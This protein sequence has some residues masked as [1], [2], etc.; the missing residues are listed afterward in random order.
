[1]AETHTSTN[2]TARKPAKTTGKPRYSG[3]DYLRV[4]AILLVFVHHW[5]TIT[6][7]DSIGK[8]ADGQLGRMGVAI[9][10]C[11]SGFLAMRTSSPP[12]KWLKYRVVRLAPSYWIT[13][14]IGFGAVAVFEIQP[15][16]LP[17]FLSQFFAIGY[18]THGNQIINDPT[19]F[20]S[21]LIICYCATT[22]ARCTRFPR[23]GLACLSVAGFILASQGW[24]PYLSWM[25]PAYGIAGIAGTFDQRRRNVFLLVTGIAAI[26]GGAFH[27]D[28]I[29]IGI[30]LLIFGAALLLAIPAHP[31]ISRMAGLIYEFFLV[32]GPLF[33]GFQLLLPENP[34]LV[35]MV[36]GIVS[37]VG[38]FILVHISDYLTNLVTDRGRHQIPQTDPGTQE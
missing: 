4:L 6:G 2:E 17:L 13:L 24:F 3:L 18:F 9:F 38:A 1:M 28:L 16:T 30:S 32:H 19:W 7:I 11:L 26:A 12:G 33:V 29:V 8:F 27:P 15:I 21:L 37:V 35:I 10:V 20:L 36:V 34:A 22:I 5:L 23:T 14:I 25:I 31:L